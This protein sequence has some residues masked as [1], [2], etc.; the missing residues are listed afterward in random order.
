MLFLLSNVG[1]VWVFLR[2]SLGKVGTPLGQALSWDFPQA[3]GPQEMPQ[4]SL[5]LEGPNIPIGN[6]SENAHTNSFFNE[7]DSAKKKMAET[8]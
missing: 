7:R 6:T 1:K 4:E 8:Q 2:I 3:S 5:G